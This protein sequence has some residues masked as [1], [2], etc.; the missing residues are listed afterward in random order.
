MLTI[1]F[2]ASVLLQLFTTNITRHTPQILSHES[3]CVSYNW[4][5]VAR[6]ARILLFWSRNQTFVLMVDISLCYK[7][8]YETHRQTF[9]FRE[10]TYREVTKKIYKRFMC[11]YRCDIITSTWFNTCFWNL[12]FFFYWSGDVNTPLI[13]VGKIWFTFE[14]WSVKRSSWNP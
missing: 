5:L 10:S 7:N 11:N 3:V 2:T 13:F 14:R 4:R 1:Y 9:N 12:N 8:A 6:Y